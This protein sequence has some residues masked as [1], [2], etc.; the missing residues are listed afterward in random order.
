M[1]VRVSEDGVRSTNFALK[2][3]YLRIP[4]TIVS[5]LVVAL[6][7]FSS[8]ALA[9]MNNG[10]SYRF[11]KDTVLVTGG[12]TFTNKLIVEN[13]SGETVQ[14]S[15]WAADTKTLSGIISIPKIIRL[16]AGEKHSYP[17]KYI[18]DRNTITQGFQTF[19]VQLHVDNAAIMVQREA[20]FFT[21][22]ED[23]GGLQIFTEQ[24]E[25]FLDQSTNRSE[26]NV[27][28]INTGLVPISFYLKLTA[29][30]PVWSFRAK[31]C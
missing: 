28:L 15:A 5:F 19:Y 17:L 6:L 18:A 25:Y 31:N 8:A 7:N 10:V 2:L 29:V 20:S 14:I 26:I 23:A 13:L 12:Q 30:L 16:A 4:I 24:D 9:Q 3:M 1:T 11:E 22:L 21:N 27:R